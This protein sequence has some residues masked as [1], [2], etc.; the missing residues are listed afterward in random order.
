MSDFTAQVEDDLMQGL[1]QLF[2]AKS[3]IL[4]MLKLIPITSL[5][6]RY[7][8]ESALPGIGFR[9]INGVF[10]SQDPG[11]I[12]PEV[13][14]LA[15]FGGPV[16]TDSVI[17]NIVTR[18]SK[19]VSKIKNAGLFFDYYFFNGDPSKIVGS[20]LGLAPRL[21]GSQVI[22]AGTNGGPIVLDQVI[23]TQDRT[24]G[25]R[26][27]EKPLFM[28]KSARRALSSQV[29]AEAKG[30]GVFDASGTQI[31]KFNDSQIVTL[32]ELGTP[33]PPLSNTE[34][35]GNNNN[36]TSIYCCW[37]GEEADQEGIQGLV[38]M[39]NADGSSPV[40]EEPSLDLTTSGSPIQ[41]KDVGDFGEYYK[42]LV[43][44]VAGLGVFHPRAATRYAG[45]TATAT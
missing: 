42:D 11:V 25:T 12:N 27:E 23:Q 44:C 29:R 9:N 7:D 26:N 31:L 13:E 38:K 14:T 41:Y 19:V 4:K 33:Q 10:G 45:I 2:P 32:D 15:I 34:T 20:F 39:F 5:A 18:R 1:I 36:T 6:Y 37:F 22:S 21:A 3:V 8:L 17:A 35:M 43:Q 30:M 40:S 28:N 24:I 16:Q